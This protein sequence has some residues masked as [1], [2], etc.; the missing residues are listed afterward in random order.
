M[1]PPF[2]TLRSSNLAKDNS[3]T[4]ETLKDALNK[5]E[6]LT[7]QH[8][9]ICVF[10][11]CT[12]IFRNTDW[13]TIAIEKLEKNTALESV[14]SGNSTHKNFWRQDKDGKFKRVS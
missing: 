7:S 12:D 4:E 9:D 14:F 5:F 1:E 11:T 6:K 10:L 8:F 13:I 3:T 2:H